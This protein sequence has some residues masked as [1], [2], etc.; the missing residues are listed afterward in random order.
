M[1][2]TLEEIQEDR[3]GWV[4]TLNNPKANAWVRKQCQKQIDKCDAEEEEVIREE[5]EK[6]R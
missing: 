3:D 2:R 5:E 1:S 6:E 4:K